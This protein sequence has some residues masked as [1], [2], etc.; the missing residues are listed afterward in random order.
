[1]INLTTRLIKTATEV[2]T[3]FNVSD[4]HSEYQRHVQKTLL[5]SPDSKLPETYYA[6][7][8][9]KAGELSKI[10]PTGIRE[11]LSFSFPECKQWFPLFW[12]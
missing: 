12:L 4:I 8:K 5:F 1:M 2:N 10:N 9:I 6:Q 7:V 11:M 3:A